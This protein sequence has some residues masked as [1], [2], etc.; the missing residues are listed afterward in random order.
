ME[1]TVV[2]A[3]TVWPGSTLRIDMFPEI[4]AR[5]AVSASRFRYSL[6]WASAACAC[7]SAVARSSFR[8]PS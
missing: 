2:P 6:A 8:V 4:G 7:A 5:S 3:A 1:K